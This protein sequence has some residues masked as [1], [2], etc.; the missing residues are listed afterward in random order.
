MYQILSCSVAILAMLYINS[1]KT[2]TSSNLDHLF[3]TRCNICNISRLCYNVS[4]RL[5]VRL[6]V[7]FVHCGHR[8]QWIPDTFACLDRWMSATYWQRL[9]RIVR[10]DDA[11]ISGGRG[12]GSSRTIL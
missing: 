5:S 7:T 9:T 6:S 12:M 10:W 8:A 11:G 4:V 2:K 3:S 1:I